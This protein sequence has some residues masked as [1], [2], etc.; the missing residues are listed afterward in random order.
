[1]K[2]SRIA[3]VGAGI[4]GLVAASALQ[5]LGFRPRIYERATELGD[6][7]AGLTLSPN[8]TN[9]LN[10][11]GF[12][13]ELEKIG[14]RPKQASVRHWQTGELKIAISRGDEMLEKFGAAYNHIH[15]ADLHSMLVN[16]VVAADSNAI[17]LGRE[18]KAINEDDSSVEID[19]RD[20]SS[21]Q[22]DVVIGADG[23][24]SSVREAMFGSDQPRFTG[25]IAFRGLVP[26]E[27]LPPDVAKPP[28]S[29]LA[30][31][32]GRSF[33]RYL[34][35]DGQILNFVALAE[36]DGWREE[37]WSI[38]ASTDEVLE[39]YAGW[40][41]DVRTIIR[42]APADKLFKWALFD[43]E[44][45]REW[46]L[47]RVTLMGDAAHPMLPF[48][49]SGAAMAIEDAVVLARSF[50]SSASIDEA[51]RRYVTARYDRTTFVMQKSREAAKAYHSG[52][53]EFSESKHIT[54]ESLGI[55]AY[56]AAQVPV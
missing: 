53:D 22:A 31:G 20:G 40:H 50:D 54:A 8:A 30:T 29:C 14:M 24:R 6:V 46:T 52:N 35:R 1:M 48:L 25:Y 4:A 28:S 27:R 39:E 17:H 19:F 23:L 41:E 7:G 56:N 45:L 42:S 44:P 3:I 18:F 34:I 38:P 36:R 21:V 47:G 10:S 11:I 16:K 5:N 55:W 33:A 15:R 2:A 37:G 51:L 12:A 9:A 13:A 49:G 32:N 43:R 26:M